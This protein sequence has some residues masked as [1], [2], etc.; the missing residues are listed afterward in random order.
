M[1][2]IIFSCQYLRLHLYSLTNQAASSCRLDENLL[3]KMSKLMTH[4]VELWQRDNA[5]RS[6]AEQQAQSLYSYKQ[7]GE[8]PETDE[9][10]LEKLTKAT[11]PTYQKVS[12]KYEA[13]YAVIYI[14]MVADSLSSCFR[15]N[16]LYTSVLVPEKAVDN[17]L[18]I[19]SNVIGYIYFSEHIYI[20]I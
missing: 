3:T 7:H 4:Y 2:I 18:F 14:K 16:S 1:F 15:E 11:F 19:S 10:L 8:V 13:M 9:Q 17:G 20:S 5:K 6:E 12:N